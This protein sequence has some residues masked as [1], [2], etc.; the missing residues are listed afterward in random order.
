L[1]EQAH[2]GSRPTARAVWR[3]DTP[4]C[5]DTPSPPRA[6]SQQ[7]PASGRGRSRTSVHSRSACS[8]HAGWAH[9]IQR[10]RHLIQGHEGGTGRLLAADDP[11]ENASIHDRRGCRRRQG[12]VKRRGAKVRIVP[13]SFLLLSPVFH[14]GYHLI[15]HYGCLGAVNLRGTHS[16]H[17]RHLLRRL[18]LVVRARDWSPCLPRSSRSAASYRCRQCTRCLCRPPDRAWPQTTRLPRAS[19]LPL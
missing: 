15:F 4:L 8:G 16:R 18:P 13:V 9:P 10:Q 3:A 11:A 5:P 17:R 1:G 6:S 12:Q 2:I 14:Y 7:R 19:A